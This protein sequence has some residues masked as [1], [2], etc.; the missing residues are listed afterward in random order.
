MKKWKRVISVV[1]VVLTMAGLLAGCNGGSSDDD[2]TLTVMVRYPT[3]NFQELES[4]KKIE[5]KYQ[6]KIKWVNVGT[7]EEINLLFASGDQCDVIMPNVLS[8]TATS[9]YA[10]QGI[11]LPLDEYISKEKTP[12]IYKMF[13]EYP[14]TKAVATLPDGKIYALPTHNKV[15]SNY[16]ESVLYINKVWL[17]KLGLEIPKTTEDLYEVLKAFKTKDPNG[18]G[19]ADEIPMSFVDG[20]SYS[21]PEALLSCWGMATKHGRYDSYLTIKNGEVKFAPIQNEWKEMIKY[22]KKLYSE[23]LLDIEAFTQLLGTFNAKTTTNPAVVGIAWSADNPFIGSDEY[24]AIP[25]INAPGYEPVWHIHPGALGCKNTVAITNN[26]KDVEGAMKWIDSFY[27]INATIENRYGMVGDTLRFEDG[28]YKFNEPEDGQDLATW[29]NSRTLMGVSAPGLFLEENIGTLI[30][31]VPMFTNKIDIYPMYK[32]YMDK[33]TW[34]RPY[35][36]AE[37]S[38][39]VGELQTD[40]FTAVEQKKDGWITGQGDIDAEWDAYVKNLYTMGLEEYIKI[41]QDAYDVYKEAMRKL[42]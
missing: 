8:D 13:E 29:T 14:T 20:D 7:E 4:V 31:A 37:Q 19:K 32:P 9:K 18:N 23:G 35:Y 21:M 22:Y 26:C 1:I 30:E 38:E 28:M 39:K 3:E 12:N 17:D 33:E 15:E 25:P 2:N 11:L 40:I 27:D 34:P 41:N 24:V 6:G 42:S 5:E 16:L 10:A 36:S